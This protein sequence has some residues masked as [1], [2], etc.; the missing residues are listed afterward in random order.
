MKSKSERR[1]ILP[2]F[3]PIG[4]AFIT[5]TFCEHGSFIRLILFGT[6]DFKYTMKLHRVPLTT[7]S[8]RPTTDEKIRRNAK[9]MAAC[10]DKVVL[11]SEL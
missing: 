10:F 11:P 3:E 7:N 6:L 2:L 4:G 5:A 8:V 1:S 9:C